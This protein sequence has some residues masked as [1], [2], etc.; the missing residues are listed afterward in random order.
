MGKKYSQWLDGKEFKNNK[1]LKR[2]YE[3]I[4]IAP[5]YTPALK[6]D[7]KKYTIARPN[8]F[9]GELSEI[10]EKIL[11]LVATH[12]FLSIK[13]IKTY[14]D[15][16]GVD[17]SMSEISRTLEDLIFFN[18]VE[19]N[20]ITRRDTVFDQDSKMYINT[21]CEGIKLYSQGCYRPFSNRVFPACSLKSLAIIK[22]DCGN[23][24]P[25]LA[26]S[27][28]I[29]NQI[30]LNNMIYNGTVRRFRVAQIKY[31][32]RMRLSVPLEIATNSRIYYFINA[33]FISTYRLQEVLS[34]W[35][36]YTTM[37]KETVSAKHSDKKQLESNK[38]GS[39]EPFT[40]VIIAANTEHLSQIM[41][42]V[43]RTD[44]KNFEV[45][46]TIYDEWFQKKGGTFFQKGIVK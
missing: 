34:N 46:F 9:N 15:L 19:R 44:T 30:L 14:L 31:L 40:I 24:M 10:Q 3:N 11:G 5:G 8:H 22:Q 39:V 2:R 25:T 33:I 12:C 20:T 16:Q 37:L 7:Y 18:L 27:M 29:I 38:K 21:D 45:A 23:A 4:D 32:P 28:H 36:D 1:L 35:N 17:I 13:Q 42:V 26:I 6:F 41:D 43:N